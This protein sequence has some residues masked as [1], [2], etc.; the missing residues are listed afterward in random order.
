MTDTSQYNA[1]A[2]RGSLDQTYTIEVNPGRPIVC[3]K[4]SLVNELAGGLIP[5]ELLNFIL[6]EPF[7]V[8]PVQLKDGEAVAKTSVQLAMEQ[9]QTWEHY[10][11]ICARSMVRPRLALKGEPPKGSDLI[12]PSDLTFAE[13]REVAYLAV[14][15]V[16]PALRPVQF[17]EP[18]PNGDGT[19]ADVP[20]SND[21]SPNTE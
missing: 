16:V 3:K 5:N 6:F 20:I 17:P 1:D 4:L 18:T 12:K 15:E 13:V 7:D 2:W 10:L 9:K 14:K 19:G 11:R 8:L 21:L